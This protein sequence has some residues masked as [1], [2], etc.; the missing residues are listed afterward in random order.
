ML[1]A[2]ARA[3]IFFDPPSYAIPVKFDQH[4]KNISR[5]FMISPGMDYAIH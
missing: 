5:I 1:V 3:I 2:P 4:L